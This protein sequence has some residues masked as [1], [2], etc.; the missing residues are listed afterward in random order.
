MK[1]AQLASILETL[2]MRSMLVVAQTKSA[3]F[4][5]KQLNAIGD[6]KE[7]VDQ[8]VYISELLQILTLNS[9]SDLINLC[10]SSEDIRA[11]IAI[12]ESQA[13]KISMWL[14]ERDDQGKVVGIRDATKDLVRFLDVLDTAFAPKS[15]TK[16]IQE[17]NL[18][19]TR[20]MLGRFPYS[21]Y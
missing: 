1:N 8:A 19:H 2:R 14:V 6:C 13:D 21:N 17:A 5:I 20:S 7:M 10:A 15:K 9:D 16:S 12:I 4:F 3:Y 18:E 11:R